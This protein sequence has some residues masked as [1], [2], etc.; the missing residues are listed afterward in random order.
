M[1]IGIRLEP[2][3]EQQLDRLAQSL[4]KTRSAC[5]RE[6]IANYLSRFDGDEEAKRQSNL[7]S[8]YSSTL[9]DFLIKP[10]SSAS[11]ALSGSRQS[12]TVSLL[13]C[14]FI[15]GTHWSSVKVITTCRQSHSCFVCHGRICQDELSASTVKTERPATWFR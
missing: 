10:S 14:G 12:R 7:I 4:G 2:E 1:A 15:V 3:L 6:A 8:A 13:L 9:S 5:V 11:S